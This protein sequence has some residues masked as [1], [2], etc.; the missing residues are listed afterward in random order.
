[1]LK[2]RVRYVIIPHCSVLV[3]LH[4]DYCIQLWCPQFKTDTDRLERVQRRATR[5]KKASANLL[6]EKRLKESGLFTLE[7]RRYKGSSSLYSRT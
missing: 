2:G 7:K 6:C 1:M 3:R 4:L 5:M